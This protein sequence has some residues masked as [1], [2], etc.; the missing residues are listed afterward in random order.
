MSKN[1]DFDTTK[2]ILWL[3]LFL[4]V[5]WV[6]SLCLKDDGNKEDS[7][8]RYGGPPYSSSCE[9]QPACLWDAARTI[10]LSNG[11]A[12][13]CTLHGIACPSFSK[14]HDRLRYMGLS[15]I[16]STDNYATRTFRTREGFKNSLD[17]SSE[18]YNSNLNY[19]LSEMQYN[20]DYSDNDNTA[21]GLGMYPTTG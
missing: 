3:F 10:Q 16:D 2:M 17:D 6:F 7:Y 20:P 1:S 13:V 21:L 8:I 14:D 12:G 19:I 15:H 5:V 18:K 9:F 11:M 4:V